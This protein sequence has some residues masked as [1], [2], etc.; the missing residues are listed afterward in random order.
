MQCFHCTA[1]LAKGSAD[2]RA[3]LDMVAKEK[4][5]VPTRNQILIYP[6]ATHFI[7]LS[8]LYTETEKKPSTIP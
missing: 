7:Q 2:P 5:L 4:D 8:K 3:I 1:A 6:I